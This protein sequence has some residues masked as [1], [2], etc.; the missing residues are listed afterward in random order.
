MRSDVG[1][2]EL[3]DVL[4]EVLNSEVVDIGI[5]ML[6]EVA[7]AMIVLEFVMSK[8]YA[9]EVPIDMRLDS[10][11]S[12]SA[13]DATIDTAFGI[14][15]GRLTDVDTNVLEAVMAFKFIVSTS[16]SDSAPFC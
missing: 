11:T 8:S 6:S 12:V 13:D 7:S 9:V 15:V 5:N 2:V 3:T 4:F 16:L 1:V 14:G 10:L